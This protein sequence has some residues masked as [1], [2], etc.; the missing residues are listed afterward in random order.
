MTVMELVLFILL[1]L[2]IRKM[3]ISQLLDWPTM[4]QA[5][6]AHVSDRLINFIVI[7]L[8][9][10]PPTCA[11]LFDG[12]NQT[13]AYAHLPEGEEWCCEHP[14]MPLNDISE[15]VYVTPATGSISII[16]NL[17]KIILD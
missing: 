12:P 17:I 4:F 2:V 1:Q 16:S 9:Q 14:I 6:H 8:C 13:G 3:R 15:S 11:I 7:K 10:G 5:T